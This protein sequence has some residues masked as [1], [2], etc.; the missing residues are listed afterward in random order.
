[1]SWAESR[2]SLEP[3]AGD[4]PPNS[5]LT[6]TAILSAAPMAAWASPSVTRGFELYEGPA[7]PEGRWCVRLAEALDDCRR[8]RLLV[9]T[10]PDRGIGVGEC[11]AL[12]ESLCILRHDIV[13]DQLMDAG[14]N[15]VGSMRATMGTLS[16]PD[17]VRRW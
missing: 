15:C 9:D 16:L 1:M 6:L 3:G 2:A 12:C 14:R 8:D 7:G 13:N 17:A 5:S 11:R 4:E 10:A